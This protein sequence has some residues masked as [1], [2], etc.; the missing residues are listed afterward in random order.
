MYSNKFKGSTDTSVVII[1][2]GLVAGI[3]FA[4][5]EALTSSD[6]IDTGAKLVAASPVPATTV[7]QP[8]NVETIVVTATRL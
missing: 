3:H 5:F 2:M 6:A 7:S 4:G 1:V 8:A